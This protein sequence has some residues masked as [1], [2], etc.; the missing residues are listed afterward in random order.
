MA[1]N[2][3]DLKLF[4]R[5]DGTGRRVPGSGVLRKSKPKNGNWVQDTTY[6]CCEFSTTTTTTTT[7]APTTTTTTTGA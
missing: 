3:Q 4:I 7:A 1:I 2:R 5:I 6:Q